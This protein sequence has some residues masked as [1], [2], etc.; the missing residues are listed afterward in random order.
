MYDQLC[1]FYQNWGY[2]CVSSSGTNFVISNRRLYNAAS[3]QPERAPVR[4]QLDRTVI[5]Y[6]PTNTG[7]QLLQEAYARG[8]WNGPWPGFK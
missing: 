2:L 6:N 7:C 8:E 5:G 4:G 3:S 1:T